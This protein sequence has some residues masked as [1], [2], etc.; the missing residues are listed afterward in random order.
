M[1]KILIVLKAWWIQTLLWKCSWLEWDGRWVQRAKN[2]N[3]SKYRLFQY[4]PVVW[5]WLI[6]NILK[7]GTLSKT[8]N[9]QINWQI[10]VSIASTIYAMV[11]YCDVNKIDPITERLNS[12]CL[13]GNHFKCNETFCFGSFGP[14]RV[15]A[16]DAIETW[17]VW[18]YSTIHF[19][20]LFI[21]HS[22][23]FYFTSNIYEDGGNQSP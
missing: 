11:R 16:R 9:I 8:N 6:M 13:F 19:H 23:L 3:R 7:A 15:L 10:L 22:I 14:T 20:A 2:I 21:F 5:L 1:S 4:R 18:V 12:R 17:Y